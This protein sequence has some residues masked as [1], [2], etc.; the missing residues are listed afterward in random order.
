MHFVPLCSIRRSI[1]LAA[2]SL[3]FSEIYEVKSTE[4]N[5][6]SKKC[7]PCNDDRDKPFFEYAESLVPFRRFFFS[8]TY[9]SQQ[10]EL[11]RANW[12]LCKSMTDAWWIDRQV[13]IRLH[14]M[15]LLVLAQFSDSA[16]GQVCWTFD[17]LCSKFVLSGNTRWQLLLE[18]GAR[19]SALDKSRLPSLPVGLLEW[20]ISC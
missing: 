8:S 12:K 1:Q 20:P 10:L 7:A 14:E 15:F 4:L 5:D 16:R 17:F 11:L 2:I 3:L 6:L 9:P 13:G 18:S 19:K